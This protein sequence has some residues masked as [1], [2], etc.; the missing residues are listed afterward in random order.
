[1][2]LDDWI[3]HG[4]VSRN[5]TISDDML[6]GVV[7]LRG[8]CPEKE[9]E[10]QSCESDRLSTWYA[11][12]NGHVSYLRNDECPF[13]QFACLQTCGTLAEATGTKVR[14]P[15]LHTFF[16][17]RQT[18]P[19]RSCTLLN[20]QRPQR[21]RQQPS[22]QLHTRDSVIHEDYR[23]RVELLR[24]IAGLFCFLGSANLMR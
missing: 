19:N 2:I 8:A 24:Q 12:F 7:A 6:A 20:Q 23:E 13:S 16:K 21:S 5:S 11:L 18:I 4:W 10:V 22:Q 1:M 15:H 17:V 14:T 9:T 3:Y